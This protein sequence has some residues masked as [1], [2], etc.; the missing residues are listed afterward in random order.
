MYDL[1]RLIGSEASLYTLDVAVAISGNGDIVAD[2]PGGAYLLT[3]IPNTNFVSEP[4]TLGLLSLGL[5]GL[6]LTLRRRSRL[7]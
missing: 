5:T 7:R 3:P 4:G 1:N 6:G 2:C